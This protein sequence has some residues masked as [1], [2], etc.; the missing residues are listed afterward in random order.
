MPVFTLLQQIFPRHHTYNVSRLSQNDAYPLAIL[1]DMLK[2][3]AVTQHVED[4][5]SDPRDPCFATGLIKARNRKA[6]ELLPRRLEAHRE[7]Q[8]G[9]Q[10]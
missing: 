2:K 8:T 3:A 10:P 6:R 1:T 5:I 7:L 9:Q 4:V